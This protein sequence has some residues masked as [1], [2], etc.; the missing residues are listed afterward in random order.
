MDSGVAATDINDLKATFSNYGHSCVD[1][2]APGKHILSTINHDPVTKALSPNAYAYASGTSLA[3]PF[4]T[5][6]AALI[7]SAYPA[8]SNAQ[9]RDRIIKSAD[10]IDVLNNGQCSGAACT[11]MLG[12]GRINASSALDPSLN[13][14]QAIQE[15]DIIE[16][17]GNP[18]VYLV[19]GGQR[20]PISAFVYNQRF[21]GTTP[22][23]VQ[24]S[25]VANLPI[26]PYALPLDN[27]IVKTA[28]DN[29]VYQI[30]SGFKRPI[31]YQIYLQ[32]S[33]QLNQIA[34]VSPEEVSSWITGKFLPPV[35]G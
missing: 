12:S 35:E 11:G 24:P 8:I 22:K 28:G 27:T 9:I 20:Q 13:T 23:V 31:T 4:V 34:I 2:S 1:V 7:K 3:A 33:I 32:R 30:V 6:E 26:G 29:T 17:A 19:T 15:G 21:S 14:V 10:P 25:D 5:A 16:V 18:Q